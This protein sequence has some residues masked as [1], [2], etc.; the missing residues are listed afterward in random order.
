M[1]IK[2][3]VLIENALLL[4]GCSQHVSTA[5]Y[6]YNKSYVTCYISNNDR[7]EVIYKQILF[8]FV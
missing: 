7:S 2:S 5:T 4:N 1:P 3:W 6:N 8:Y